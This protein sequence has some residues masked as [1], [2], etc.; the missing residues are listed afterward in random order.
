MAMSALPSCIS[1]ARQPGLPR[2]PPCGDREP[3]TETQP[4]P[5]RLP[6]TPRCETVTAHRVKQSSRPASR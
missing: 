6:R 5:G 3:S 2:T 4:T 1:T